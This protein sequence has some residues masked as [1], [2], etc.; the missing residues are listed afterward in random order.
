MG[1][2]IHLFTVKYFLVVVRLL[3]LIAELEAFEHLIDGRAQVDILQEVLLLF[4]RELTPAL[5]DR[6]S[7]PQQEL[8]DVLHAAGEV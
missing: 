8:Q 4:E 7:S 6:L 3:L 2:V 5:N 1:L